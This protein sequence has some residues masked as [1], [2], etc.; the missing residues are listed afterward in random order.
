[1]TEQQRIHKA[2][3]AII[4]ATE[5]SSAKWIL[6]GSASLMLRGLDLASEPRDLDIYCDDEDMYALYEALKPFAIDEPEFSVT[7]IY[8]SRLCHFQIENVQVELVG[9][10]QVS[11]GGSSYRTMVR[12]LLIPYS[13]SV[14]LAGSGLTAALVPLAHELW[15]N[16]LRDRKDR[17]ELIVEAF[18]NLFSKHVDAL[19]AIEASNTL[20]DDTK[21]SLHQLI[22]AKKVGG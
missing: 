4:K 2:L 12:E 6:G 7:D 17:V 1:M 14:S 21:G 13:E 16:Y 3:A 15:F 20:A 22:S 5:A 10:F 19:H 9:G 8:R 18:A 11:A